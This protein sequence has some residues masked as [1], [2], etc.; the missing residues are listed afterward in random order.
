MGLFFRRYTSRLNLGE[1]EIKRTLARRL[2][3]ILGIVVLHSLAFFAFE[4]VTIGEALWVTV[5]TL[6]T[7]GYGDISATTA[8]GQISTTVLCFLVGIP[9]LASVW[10][11]YAS[12]RDGVRHQK[13]AGLYNWNLKDHILIAN[14]PQDYTIAQMVRL[15]RAIRSQKSLAE[16]PIQIITTRFDGDHLPQD[17][18][19]LGNIAHVNG[20][21]SSK[22]ALALATAEEASHVVV[23]RDRSDNDPEGHS[24][25][26]CAR[27]RDVNKDANITVQVED[28]HSRSALRLYRAG[29]SNLL[30]PA[31]AYPEIIA[32]SM[33]TKGV[34]DL[35]EDLLSIDGTEFRLIPYKGRV[36]WADILS[37]SESKDYGSPIGVQKAFTTPG[38]TRFYQPFL[39]PEAS[40]EGDIEGVYVISR[41]KNGESFSDSEWQELLGKESVTD[42]APCSQ[43]H[44]LNL[45]VNQ[46]C[47]LDY[48]SSLLYQLRS[49]AKYA[50]SVIRVISEDIPDSIKTAVDNARSDSKHDDQWIWKNVE[51]IERVP[52]DA[53]FDSI[54]ANTFQ[55]DFDRDSV[56]AILNNDDDNDPDGYTYELI[57]LLRVEGEYAGMIIAEAESDNERE[58]LYLTG[59]DHCLRPVRGYPGMLARTLTNPGV[60][61]A[62]EAFFRFNDLIIK[63]MTLNSATVPANLTFGELKKR[64]SIRSKGIVPLSIRHDGDVEDVICPSDDTDIEVQNCTIL[65]LSRHG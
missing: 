24:F 39:A 37:L 6:T 58:R 22:K 46:A 11:A 56:V 40:F 63:R 29:A 19:D 42:D 30:R 48:L 8:F 2:R 27:L 33:I 16:K 18:I 31:K 62:I 49:T 9:I 12:W 15:I 52:S 35:F 50:D 25:N 13:R 5:T 60:E 4:P 45:P 61:K 34:N 21:A 53:I 51:L 10:D 3:W 65:A 23:L 14:F 47:P 28:P 54:E 41:K 59:A 7:V 38:G 1:K 44:I 32:L 64:D 57:D 20:L 26:I 17:L 36:K 43:L 55:E